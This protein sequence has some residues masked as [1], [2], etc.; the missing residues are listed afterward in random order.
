[1]LFFFL[2]G[3]AGDRFYYSCNLFSFPL[4]IFLPSFSKALESFSTLVIEFRDAEE[5]GTWLRGLMQATYRASV[6]YKSLFFLLC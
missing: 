5:K 3:G 4:L 1:M 2:C 6:Q